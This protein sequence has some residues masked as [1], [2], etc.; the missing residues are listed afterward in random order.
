M[1]LYDTESAGSP[2]CLREGCP[3]LCRT[4]WPAGWRRS[5]LCHCSPHQTPGS[6]L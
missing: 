2:C 6:A 5:R 1:I 3:D 4:A